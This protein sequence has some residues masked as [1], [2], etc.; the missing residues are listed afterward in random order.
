MKRLLALVMCLT[1]LMPS[2]ASATPAT[3]HSG[4]P[5][6]TGRYA[7]GRDVL[8]LVDHH[9]TD[10]WVPE[11]GARQLMVSMYYPAR[12]G[13]GR[14]ASYMTRAEAQLLLERKAP[15]A[16][17]PP[18]VISGLPVHARADAR[19]APGP[20]PLVVLSPGLTLPRAT[21]TSLAEDLTSHGYVVALVDHTYE[22]SG[23]TFPDGRT[24]TCAI[25]DQPP[26]GG[27]AA[28]AA[29]RARDIS[30]VLD[31]VTGHHTGWRYAKLIDPGRIG[32]AGHSIGGAASATAM[33]ADPRIR[34]GVNMDGTFPAA[35]PPT[36]LGGRA[37]LL[38]GTRADHA[39]GRDHT[40]DRDWPNL[41]GWK[42]WLTVAG[43][44]HGSFTDTPIL[45]NLL[46]VP[47]SAEL[48]AQRAAEITR[49]YV[50]AFFDLHLKCT[51]Q[52]VLDGVSANNPEVAF[53]QPLPAPR[54]GYER[55]HGDA[56]AAAGRS[57]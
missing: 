6:P 17:A 54:I 56:S 57:R 31:Q 46:G 49:T 16:T 25:C 14:P 41:D 45:E 35:V 52:P 2:T 36:G 27:P 34:A 9:R 24:L 11:A 20:F 42:R 22:S 50:T 3:V 21:L 15:D 44:Q 43:A 19:P 4:L 55:H 5:R 8:E 40:W 18:E 29:S 38:L 47:D 30:F 1:V 12:P 37:F 28:I 51:P 39:P 7:V 13:T 10:P 33:V 48:P 32:L 26:E 53:E 23:T